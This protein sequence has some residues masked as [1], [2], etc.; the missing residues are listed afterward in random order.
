MK[1]KLAVGIVLVAQLSAPLM[2]KEKVVYGDDNRVNANESTNDLFKTLA[3]S[4]AAMIPV[5][6]VEKSMEGILSKISGKTLKESNRLCDGERFEAQQT[7]AMC[8]GFLIG[9]DLLVT[10]GHCMRGGPD[11][12]DATESKNL[13]CLNNY[14]VFDYRQDLIG[15]NPGEVYV[16][17]KSVYKCA[18]VISQVLDQSTKNDFAL[19]KLERVVEDRD[20]LKFRTEGKIE[21]ATEIVV[22]GHPSGLPTI[23]SDGAQVRTNTNPY[24]FVANLDTFGGNSGSAVFDSETGLVEGILV[25]GEND[26]KYNPERGCT[27]VF[28]CENDKCRGEDVTRITMIPELAPGQQP[29]APVV[30]TPVTPSVLDFPF[31]MG[32]INFEDLE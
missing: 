14:W 2:A 4:T 9:P 5:S 8:S 16:N 7:A 25:R 11:L 17:S 28:T 1:L 6:A 26:Y 29:V 21:D 19:I 12:A 20:P 27:E 32:S 22:I 15:D 30:V 3:K 13:N 31:F 23:I 24:F 10:A 18:K